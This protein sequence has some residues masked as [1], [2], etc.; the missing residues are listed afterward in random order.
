LIKG[1][2]RCHEETRANILRSKHG[3]RSILKRDMRKEVL[4][5]KRLKD[6]LGLQSIRVPAEGKRLAEVAEA[7][8]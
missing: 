5:K 1:D 6:E 3:K 7:R 8:R 4:P 2:G